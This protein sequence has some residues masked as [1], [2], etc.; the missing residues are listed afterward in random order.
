[1]YNIEGTWHHVSP[2]PPIHTT[3]SLTPSNTEKS[4]SSSYKDIATWAVKRPLTIKK[5]QEP[6][7]QKASQVKRY[8]PNVHSALTGKPIV[9]SCVGTPVS[10][11]HHWSDKPRFPSRVTPVKVPR[12]NVIPSRALSFGDAKGDLITKCAALYALIHVVV[13]ACRYVFS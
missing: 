9:H 6:E 12:T 2:P 5:H 3:P 7:M 10:K 1:M 11:Q 8:Q 13:A 4:R